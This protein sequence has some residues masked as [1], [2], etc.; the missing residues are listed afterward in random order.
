VALHET[1][2]AFDLGRPWVR[3][4]FLGLVREIAD[5]MEFDLEAV[6][7]RLEGLDLS[8]PGR[9]SEALGGDLLAGA[10]TEEQQ[11][12]LRRVQAF[13]A[14]AEGHADHVMAAVGRSRLPS[15]D[16]IDEAM[17]RRHE[18]RSEEERA[19]ERLLGVDMKVEQYRLGRTFSDRVVELTDERTLARMWDSPEA[20]PS[21]PELEEPRLWLA[22]M[23]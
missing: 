23:A 5:G 10:L 4:H 17:R 14:A 19:A 3:D 8:D 13:M 22:R 2:H 16:R 7:Q 12:L 18:G 21:M 20:L 11:L 1:T 9:V 6:Q 15:F